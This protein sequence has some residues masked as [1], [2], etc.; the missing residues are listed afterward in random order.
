M[1]ST[2]LALDIVIMVLPIREILKLQMSIRRKISV[3]LVFL[4]G[5]FVIVTG[6][7]R[8]ILTNVLTSPGKHASLDL[9]WLQVHV[10]SGVVCACIPTYLPLLN[11]MG[12]LSQKMISSL[13][14]RLSSST[15]GSKGATGNS[16]ASKEVRTE[17]HRSWYRQMDESR[18]DNFVLIDIDKSDSIDKSHSIDK[19]HS[20]DKIH[21]IDKAHM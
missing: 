13:T 10:A 8:M 6:I 7:V 15:G 9:I 3:S 4:M 17:R 20:I 14:S 5:S 2:E 19:G 18:S 21:S 1:T 12:E 11:K 16:N